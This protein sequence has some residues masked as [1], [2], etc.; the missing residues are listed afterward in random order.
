MVNSKQ[1]GARGERELAKVLR[2]YGY[3]DV[4]RSQQYSGKGQDSSDL[5]NLPGIHPECKRQERLNI[6]DAVAQAVNDCDNGKLPTVF[7]RKNRG[8]WLVTLRLQDFIILY[9]EYES[10]LRLAGIGG[11]YVDKRRDI[12]NRAG[13]DAK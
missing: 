3:K 9:R 7:H 4:V 2:D 10:G 1:K 6:L 11:D 12:G 13:D 5:V 8:E